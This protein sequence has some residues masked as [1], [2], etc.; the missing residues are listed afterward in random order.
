MANSELTVDV[1]LN[2]SVDEKT[3]NRALHIVE[4]LLEDNPDKTIVIEEEDGLRVCLIAEK[5]ENNGEKQG[6]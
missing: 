5:G 1:T 3:I 6:E 4:Q 2:F